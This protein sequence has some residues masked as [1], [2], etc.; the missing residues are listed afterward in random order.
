MCMEC[1]LQL[2]TCPLCRHDIQ[3]RVRLIAHVS[4]HTSC[5]LSNHE[6]NTSPT[7]SSSTSPLTSSRAFRTVAQC[8]SVSRSV[9]S[10]KR[11]GR[12][13]CE[14]KKG[15]RWDEGSCDH[16]WIP[17]FLYIYSFVYFCQLT[18]EA[19]PNIIN[20]LWTVCFSRDAS[21]VVSEPTSFASPFVVSSLWYEDPTA[22]SM[23]RLH[24]FNPVPVIHVSANL[25]GLG[26]RKECSL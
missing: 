2:E 7:A 26:S 5:L 21:G 11:R 24:L 3:T 15:R 10:G 22:F 23:W 1:A 25:T 20:V 6:R 16:N 19:G 8:C 4:W 17:S 12:W 9:T 18:A 14:E 13:R